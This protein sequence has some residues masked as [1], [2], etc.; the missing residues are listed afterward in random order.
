M[1]EQ[2]EELKK[3]TRRTVVGSGG[4]S[5]GKRDQFVALPDHRPG[6]VGKG[7]DASGA[8]SNLMLPAMKMAKECELKSQTWQGLKERF[9]GG[10][11]HITK[12][13]D[14]EKILGHVK[15]GACGDEADVGRYIDKQYPSPP[16]LAK[17]LQGIATTPKGVRTHKLTAPTQLVTTHKK[18]LE[19]AHAVAK[20]AVSA[21]TA[22]KPRAAG[23]SGKMHLP[24]S[25]GGR[26][27]SINY[28]WLGSNPLGPLEKFNIFSWRALGHQVNIYTHP[29]AG[30]AAHTEATL[31]LERGDVTVISL[32]DTLTADD[33]E[34]GEDHP[35]ALLGDARSLLKRWLA[36]IPKEGRPSIEH[37]FNMVDL[38]KSYLGGTQ[39]G[40]VLDMKVGPSIHLQDYAASF[41]SHLV[42]YTRGGNTVEG[43][44]E[45]QCIGT[46]QGSEAL[47]KCYAQ[48]FNSKVKRLAEEDPKDPWFNQITGYHGLSYKQ[49]KTWLDVALKTP[50]G[51]VATTD[52]F[53]VSEPGVSGH[54][55]FRVFKRASD[56]TNKNAGKTKP[57]EVKSLADDVL[58]KELL[59]SGVDQ[60]FVGKAQAAAKLLPS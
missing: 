40:I 26:P 7:D 60:A 43:L 16:H 13:K 38:T 56:Q 14:W 23:A 45:N 53:S 25:K 52:E 19:V 17:P 35:K 15:T 30:G 10:R 5:N 36:G 57:M 34:A 1:Y 24:V 58:M 42:S 3:E 44:P 47:R 51:L 12:F 6:P 20:P 32:G 29:F 8:T 55:P 27:L 22:T 50:S 33:R 28:V 59:G 41:D 21:K 18:Q 11:E 39:R 9:G 54:G 46:M 37:I 48:R 2:S 4:G 49:T 31:G